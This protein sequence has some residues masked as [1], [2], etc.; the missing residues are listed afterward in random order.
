MFDPS[1][2]Q[3]DLRRDG[4]LIKCEKCQSSTF[5]E[6]FYLFKISKLLTGEAQD[7]HVPVPTFKCTDC[8]HINSDVSMQEESSGTL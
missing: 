8:G 7:A 2:K 6:V 5:T 1:K 4:T 3:I